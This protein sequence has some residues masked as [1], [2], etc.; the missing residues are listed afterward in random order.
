MGLVFKNLIFVT[1]NLP[2]GVEL[3]D[4]WNGGANVFIWGL[5]FGTGEIIWG[6]KFG[7]GGIIWGLKFGTGGIIWGLKFQGPKCAYLMSFYVSKNL[8][9]I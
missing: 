6:L 9:P 3:L 5:K 1:I 4:F 8:L 7:T 2:L